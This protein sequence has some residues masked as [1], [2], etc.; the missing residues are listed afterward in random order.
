MQLRTRFF[1]LLAT[2][3]FLGGYVFLAAAE[4]RDREASRPE[5]APIGVTVDPNEPIGAARLEGGGF[6]FAA[7]R[8]TPASR[9]LA[10]GVAKRIRVETDLRYALFVPSDQADAAALDALAGD[11]QR[12]RWFMYR[13]KPLVYVFGTA[14]V[15]AESRFSIIR[16]DNGPSGDQYWISN[17]PNIKH[18]LITLT[19]SFAGGGLEIDPSRT[20]TA[21][22]QQE[23]FAETN[24]DRA[25]LVLWHSWNVRKDR[26]AL[27]PSLIVDTDNPPSYAYERVKAFN[28][29]WKRP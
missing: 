20:G 7:I 4:S 15:P 26:S 19:P 5:P 16:I 3:L 22:D 10:A 25:V 9:V 8:W 21:L 28:E 18:G 17:P 11:F 12:D 27:L 23:L 24:K 29:R 14:K 13:G 6:D 1:Y 2:L